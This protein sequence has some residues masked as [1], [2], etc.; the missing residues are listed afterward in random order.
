MIATLAARI[1]IAALNA[2]RTME[3]EQYEYAGFWIRV[4]ATLIDVFGAKVNQGFIAS[5]LGQR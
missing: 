4:G 5:C 3:D 2:R 1:V